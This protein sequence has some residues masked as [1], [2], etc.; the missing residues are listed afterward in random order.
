MLRS[1]QRRK[2]T[3]YPLPIHYLNYLRSSNKRRVEPKLSGGIKPMPLGGAPCARGGA[4]DQVAAPADRARCHL[5]SQYLTSAAMSQYLTS[6][7]ISQYLTSAAISAANTTPALLLTP[8]IS[9]PLLFLRLPLHF[10][11]H[12]SNRRQAA[13][14][15]THAA[16]R[17]VCCRHRL[18]PQSLPSHLHCLHHRRTYHLAEHD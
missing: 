5:R 14:S 10:P 16:I 12:L 11:A 8:S 6:A 13:A 18:L 1:K 17:N 2:D 15:T 3:Y 7:A 9:H 4:I